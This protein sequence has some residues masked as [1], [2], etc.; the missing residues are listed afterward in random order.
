MAEGI[1]A[2]EEQRR[3]LAETLPPGTVADEVIRKLECSKRRFF[4]KP[5]QPQV[6][7]GT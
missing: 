4:G 1:A 5:G 7:H 3:V 6:K 2:D